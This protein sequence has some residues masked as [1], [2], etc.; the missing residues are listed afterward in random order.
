MAVTVA[1]GGRGRRAGQPGQPGGRGG[2]DAGQLGQRVGRVLRRDQVRGQ[3]N[4]FADARDGVTAGRDQLARAAHQVAR[5]LDQLAL[6]GGHA[7]GDG[8][9]RL[10]QRVQDR[11]LQRPAIEVGVLLW[12]QERVSKSV[13]SSSNSDFVA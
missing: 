12:K 8:L 13:N 6:D 7:A 3:G 11:L 4:L 2:Q 1:G 5:A 9:H 10:E